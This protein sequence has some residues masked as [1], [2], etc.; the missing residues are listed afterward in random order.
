MFYILLS[1]SSFFIFSFLFS[2]THW[3]TSDPALPSSLTDRFFL[4]HQTQLF[5]QQR[6]NKMGEAQADHHH[7]H[8]DRI[9]TP[10]ESSVLSHRHRH[11]DWTQLFSH[12]HSDRII[13][14]G[15]A[16]DMGEATPIIAIV[17]AAS[18]DWIISLLLSPSPLQLDPTLLSSLLRWHHHRWRRKQH[19]RGHFDHRHCHR[20]SDLADLSLSFL[21]VGCFD[22]WWLA[23]F[24]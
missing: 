1:L 3:L 17:M 7:C 12:R 5:P 11:S 16:S 4:S 23:D 18:I 6:K 13:A 14:I 22:C 19:G 10:I 2:L 20:R 24:G 9:T 15:G 21:V 8:S